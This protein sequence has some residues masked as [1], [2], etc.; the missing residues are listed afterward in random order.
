MTGQAV[1]LYAETREEHKPSHAVSI[2]MLNS[3][4]I[5]FVCFILAYLWLAEGKDSQEEK[6]KKKCK[7]CEPLFTFSKMVHM[8]ASLRNGER[9]AFTSA[10]L[11]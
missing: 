6:R 4:H 7:V 11:R 5:L 2:S 3:P 8:S 1:M 10:I 9:S